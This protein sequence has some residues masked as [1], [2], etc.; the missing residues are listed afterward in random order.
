MPESHNFQHLPLVFREK[1]PAR[2]TGGGK[3]SDTTRQNRQNRQSHSAGL[4]R[5]TTSFISSWQS[6]QTQRQQE[7]MPTLPPGVPLL[8]EVDPDLDID[9]LRHHLGF[10]VVA[11]EEAGFVIVASEDVNLAI[12]L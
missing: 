4:R 1:G 8:L 11:E 3:V 10:E 7:N 2:L 6:R 5:S 9:A 12:F